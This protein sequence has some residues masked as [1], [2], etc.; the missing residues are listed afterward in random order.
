MPIKARSSA[1]KAQ[2]I[3]PTLL[4]FSHVHCSPGYDEWT[5]QAVLLVGS[6][7][8]TTNSDKPL[9]KW[10]SRIKEISDEGGRNNFRGG[11]IFSLTL[12]LLYPWGQNRL[13]SLNSRLGG[14]QGQSGRFTREKGAFLDG[15]DA[16][17]KGR[18][19]FGF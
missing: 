6:G 16:K 8:R 17:Y 7:I 1:D 10:L 4:T 5:G 11:V 9:T 13:Y 18:D 19:S 3:H 14:P 12:R 2:G 15:M